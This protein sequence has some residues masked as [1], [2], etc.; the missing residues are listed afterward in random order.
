MRSETK[1][2]G[3][4]TKGMS[5]IAIATILA[6]PA[7]PALADDDD[8]DDVVLP[9][10]SL[11]L[12]IEVTDND[13]ELQAFV[14]GNAWKRLEIFDPNE[15]RVFNLK[16]Q[17]RLGRQGLSEM[18]I[19]SEPDHFPEDALA[20]SDEANEVVEAF[21]ARFPEGDY[22]IEGVDVNQNELEGLATLTHVLA[23]LPEIVAPVSD[24]DEL[25]VVDSNAL[26]IEWESVTT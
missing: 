6:L 23:A 26:V 4:L 21:F 9:F 13:I 24:N 8:S 25:P 12:T 2:Y 19:A 20:P 17:R 18:H 3:Y 11:S 7:G 10:K 1:R 5:A 14:D 15:R 16:T 22:E